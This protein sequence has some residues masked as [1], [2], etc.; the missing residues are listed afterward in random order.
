MVY[1]WID[2]PGPDVG[3]AYELSSPEQAAGVAAKLVPDDNAERARAY[4]LDIRNQDLSVEQYQAGRDFYGV[5]LL[6]HLPTDIDLPIDRSMI[7]H[8]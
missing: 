1:L 8:S 4:D 7:E 6:D 3:V 5:T 2:P